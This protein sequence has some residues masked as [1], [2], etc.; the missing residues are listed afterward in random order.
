MYMY[1]YVVYS[2]HAV[3]VCQTNNQQ[4][5]V[6]SGCNHALLALQPKHMSVKVN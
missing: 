5:E 2:V 1:T 6:K 3:N 4:K